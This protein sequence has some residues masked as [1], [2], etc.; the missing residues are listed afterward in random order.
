MKRFSAETFGKTSAQNNFSG[1]DEAVWPAKQRL[2]LLVLCRGV[3]PWGGR[4][5]RACSRLGASGRDP[6]RE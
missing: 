5:A 2:N 3:G 4:L 6:A 1:G